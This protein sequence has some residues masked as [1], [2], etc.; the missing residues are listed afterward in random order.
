MKLLSTYL[1]CLFLLFF[2]EIPAKNLFFIVDNFPPD[3]SKVIDTTISKSAIKSTINYFARD[4]IPIDLKNNTLTLYGDAWVTYDKIR[5]DAAIIKIDWRKQLLYADGILDKK[6]NKYIGEPKMTDHGQEYR[7]HAI[8]YNFKTRRAKIS[9]LIT[10][11]GEGFIHGESVK[12]DSQDNV[13]A[14]HAKYTTCDLDKPHFYIY[15][16]KVEILKDKIISGPAYMVVEGIPIPIAVPFGFF[17]KKNT[18]SSGII[19]PVYGESNGR[20]FFLKGIGYYFGVNDYF[21]LMLKGDIYSRG[22]WLFSVGSNYSKR[23]RYSGNLN[24]V[25]AHNKFGDPETPDY[26]MSKDF[27]ITWSHVQDPKAHPTSSFSANVNAG[28]QN[29]YRNT[30][31]NFD[32]SLQNTLSSAVSWSKRFPGSPFS[33]TASLTHSQNL[34]NKTISLSAPNYSL[35]MARIFPFKNEKKVLKHK[36]YE[37]IGLSYTLNFRNTINT[38]DSMFLK[39]ETWNQWKYAF[40][41]DIPISTSFRVLKYFTLTPSLNYTGRT[42]FSRELRT[43]KDDSVIHQEERGAYHLND[44]NASGS[45]STRIYGMYKINRLKIIAIRHVMSPS[46]SFVYKPDFATSPFNY[47]REVQV[48]TSGKMQSY[49]PYQAGMFSYPS[50]G[51]QGN[52]V[53]NLQNNLEAKLKPKTDTGTVEP[54]K[55][56]LLE[57]F[58]MSVAYNTFAD[59]MKLSNI[60]F[61]M[62]SSLFQNKLGIQLTAIL[63]PYVINADSH[64][65]DRLAISDG[66]GLGHLTN[67]NITLDFSIDSKTGKKEK[68]AKDKKTVPKYPGEEMYV[69]FDVPWNMSFYYT[70]SYANYS[71]VGNKVINKSQIIQTLNFNGNITVTPKWK[72]DFRSGFDI[73][74]KKFS[75]TSINVHRDLHCWQMSFTW[76]PF[77]YWRSYMFT[78]NV[79]SSVLKDL[80]IDKKREFF[81]Y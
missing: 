8:I 26:S 50:S 15:S 23:Y 28:S 59:S 75:A 66:Y 24:I 43:Y 49:T 22:S 39:K 46:L 64:V 32:Q 30:S 16:S 48:D 68:D 54:R 21:D 17:P 74:S 65:V 73:E 72:L 51:K 80:K 13:Y 35:N 27:S 79:K 31:Y 12:K 20:G 71:H 3:S 14:S 69:D 58:G 40:K 7:S 77:G 60:N 62:R 33:M 4:S 81:D 5:L 42:Y 1:I 34:S 41:Q 9:G 70:L 63:D 11:E 25:Y 10:K 38:T 53:F 2:I 18:R 19:L 61:D 36:W 37:D 6:T 56:T 55:V 44:F 47:Y 78:L 67:V 52:I 45:L 57:S 76:I 29:S